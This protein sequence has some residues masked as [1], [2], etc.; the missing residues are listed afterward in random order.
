MS[1]RA[2]PTGGEDPSV[3]RLAASER[4][5]CLPQCRSKR[6]PCALGLGAC[7]AGGRLGDGGGGCEQV[8]L[9]VAVGD[10]TADRTAPAPQPG[11][12]LPT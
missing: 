1:Q 2:S 5:A 9:A 10:G 6:A 12:P 4:R 3:C 7:G 8:G 11:T